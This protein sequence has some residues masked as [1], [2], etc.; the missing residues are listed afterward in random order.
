MKVTFAI[1]CLL[2]SPLQKPFCIF[3]KEHVN[4]Y[5]LF[6]NQIITYWR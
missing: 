3:K 6:P 1:P 4:S 2:L 5:T